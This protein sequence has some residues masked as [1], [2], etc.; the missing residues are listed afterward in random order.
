MEPMSTLFLMVVCPRSRG[1]SRLE[2]RAAAA[3]LLAILPLLVFVLSYWL[4]WID[5]H[6]QMCSKYQ[7]P[8]LSAVKST[9]DFKLHL[10]DV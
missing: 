7:V 8:I 4:V 6:Q 3:A 5:V 9:Q 1:L 2:K 10:M